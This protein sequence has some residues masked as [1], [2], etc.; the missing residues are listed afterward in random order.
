MADVQP[1]RGVRYSPEAGDLSALTSPPYDVISA[2]ERDALEARDPHNVVRMVLGREEPGDAA[3]SNKYTRARD[4]LGSWLGAGVLVREDVPA[5]YV[6]EQRYRLGGAERIQRGVLAAVGLADDSVVPHERT[7]AA[8]VADRL[9]LMRATA[10]NL[11]PI[12]VAHESADGAGRAVVAKAADRPPVASFSTSDGID[13]RLWAVS[14]AAA[15]RAVADDAAGARFLIADGHHRHRTALAYRAER[16]ARDGDGP[17]DRMLMMIVD[18]A[19][20]GP[21]VLPI[22][23]LVT[24]ISSKSALEAL[25]GTFD[26]EPAA[27]RDVAEL[28]RELAER[29]ASARVYTIV[30]REAAWWVTLADKAAADE[31][32]PADR[33]PAW[34]D[35]DVAV[36]QT[37]VFERLLHV[38]PSYAHTAAEV[39]DAL[40]R[41]EADCAVLVAPTPFEAVRRV[42]ESGE[43]MPPKS[44]FFY[45]KPRSGVVIR[46]LDE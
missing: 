7:M 40:E 12:I 14:D 4:A 30:D 37:L 13:H 46:L 38:S 9:E 26:V 24:G 22:H 11:E 41:R 27:T 36:L 34:R 6:Y 16:R 31:A 25:A 3:T 15:I 35:L 42:A 2:A 23:R 17:W 28:E 45:P 43:A 39:N 19:W 8:P 5:V 1:F 33:S 20:Y 10:A 44:T 32:M 29:R 18:P 21:S